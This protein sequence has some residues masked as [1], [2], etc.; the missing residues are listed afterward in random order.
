MPLFLVIGVHLM[1]TFLVLKRVC[2]GD[3]FLCSVTCGNIEMFQ[4]LAMLCFM[5]N[6]SAL[7]DWEWNYI[8]AVP[9]MLFF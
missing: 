9:K 7:R 8:A 6:N 3:R 2:S 5:I 1:V 4:N